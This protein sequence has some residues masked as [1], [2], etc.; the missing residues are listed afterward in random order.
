MA[1]LTISGVVYVNDDASTTTRF[2][3]VELTSVGLTSREKL[4]PQAISGMAD[5]VEPITFDISRFA[6]K[7]VVDDLVGIATTFI[8]RPPRRTMSGYIDAVVND[9]AELC[10]F[11]WTERD[12]RDDT[13]FTQEE[14]GF[15][16]IVSPTVRGT[17]E[18]L[19]LV[20]YP[21]DRLRFVN[22]STYLSVEP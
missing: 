17:S 10:K 12:R 15:F 1:T 5:L 22:S 21:V 7:K 9:G 6:R 4:Y 8:A 14:H 19:Q 20:L 3:A 13:T 18:S 16:R 11:A 2:T